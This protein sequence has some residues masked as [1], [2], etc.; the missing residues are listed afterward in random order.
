ML[1]KF[2]VATVFL[3]LMATVNAQSATATVVYGY[4]A[5]LMAEVSTYTQVVT[6]DNVL[7]PGNPTCVQVGPDVSCSIPVGTVA[8]G[9]HTLS[10][11]ATKNNV[12]AKTTITG[13]DIGATAPKN[14]VNFRYQLQITVNLP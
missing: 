12:T 2:V 9:R 8:A 11:E 14:P 13:L 7:I 3:G 5:V 4:P 1:K 10:V 6:V